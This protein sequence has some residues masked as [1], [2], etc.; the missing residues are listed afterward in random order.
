MLFL[1]KE[2]GSLSFI[3]YPAGISELKSIKQCI[4]EDKCYLNSFIGS[5]VKAS[6]LYYDMDLVLYL[7]YI[8]LQ[9]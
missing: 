5:G 2:N 7:V 9:V 8:T 6:R 3:A 4:G 1:Y